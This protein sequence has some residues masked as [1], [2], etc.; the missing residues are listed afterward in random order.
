LHAWFR[1]SGQVNNSRVRIGSRLNF[2]DNERARLIVLGGPSLYQPLREGILA[3]YREHGISWWGGG[4]GPTENPISSQIACIN[5]LEPARL[6]SELAL[7]LARKHVPNA[8][9]VLPIDGGF[10]A[11]EWIGKCNYLNEWNWSPTSRGHH[12]T[13][14]DAVMAVKRANGTICI[15]VI[16]WKYTEAYKYGV[17]LATS[18]RGTSRIE[19]YRA[20]LEHADSP[21]RPGEHERLFFDPFDQLMRQTL[22]AWQMVK[23]GEFGATEWLHLHVAPL[24]NEELLG[25]VTSPMLADF[26]DMASAWRSVL[27]RPELYSLVTPE[28]MIPHAPVDRGHRDWRQWLCERYGT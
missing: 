1:R 9:T 14:L 28:T 10:L 16:E 13:S 19:I 23:H 24:A 5:H 18:K 15:L 21:I 12:V 7:D 26:G 4:D 20:L 8:I 22:L 27:K 6:S 11:Y 3:Y 2:R 17:S 25:M